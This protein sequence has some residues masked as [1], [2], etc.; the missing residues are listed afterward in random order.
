MDLIHYYNLNYISEEENSI[1]ETKEGNFNL[2]EDNFEPGFI[3]NNFSLGNNNSP[4]FTNFNKKLFNN[5]SR[6]EIKS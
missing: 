5:F 4:K 2:E 1:N 3:N 6:N